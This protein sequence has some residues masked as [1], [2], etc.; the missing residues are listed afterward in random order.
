MTIQLHI[1]LPTFF[2]LQ[3]VG[4]T[5]KPIQYVTHGK[6]N[7][8]EL[9]MVILL[10]RWALYGW[11]KWRWGLSRWVQLLV[12]QRTRLAGD[13][14]RLQV[15]QAPALEGLLIGCCR[16]W[17]HRRL[18]TITNLFDGLQL[19]AVGVGGGHVG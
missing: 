17:G 16:L 14:L 5:C 3:T 19:D 8:K 15:L 4:I 11:V 10:C 18:C 9:L 2:L 12:I 7:C 1:L 6:C 13:G